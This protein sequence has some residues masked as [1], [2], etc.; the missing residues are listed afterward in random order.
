M[1]TLGMSILLAQQP[2]RYQALV[3]AVNEDLLQKFWPSKELAE[4]ASD[5][6]LYHVRRRYERIGYLGFSKIATPEAVTWY[7][8]RLRELQEQGSINQCV[9]WLTERLPSGET[10]AMLEGFCDQ[11]SYLTHKVFDRIDDTDALS[12]FLGCRNTSLRTSAAKRL[13]DL[14]LLERQERQDN[15]SL[16]ESNPKVWPVLIEQSKRY[17]DLFIE[18]T[19]SVYDL[20]PQELDRWELLWH[21]TVEEDSR[22]GL[23]DELFDACCRDRLGGDIDPLALA[24]RLYQED[25]KPFH[26][27]VDEKYESYLDDY[28][29]AIGKQET[30]LWE[31]IPK[32]AARYLM[33]STWMSG[34]I[35]ALDPAP[36]QKALVRYLESY[37]ALEDKAQV[38]LLP[39][40]NDQTV[41][42]CG[43]TLVELFAKTN[44]T[45]YQP[46][47]Q[48]INRTTTD[49]LRESGLLEL[50]GKKARK[51]ML[52]DLALHAAVDVAP[53][54]RVD[55][56]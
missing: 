27:F 18:A 33:Q 40:F 43:A 21:S 13:H 36:V 56:E 14:A 28:I 29:A 2:Q 11:E 50:S 48:L 44:K 41:I 16:Y 52:T 46:A 3:E 38:K 39:F 9:E 37:A 47:V 42:A 32:M 53:V 54:L 10:L 1:N 22:K 31:L 19:L 12:R 25:P 15:E 23:A 7:Q 5:L 30:P 35:D 51:L 8:Q 49:V 17:P 6:L 20:N 4:T 24:E 45:L 26:A 55:H 34:P